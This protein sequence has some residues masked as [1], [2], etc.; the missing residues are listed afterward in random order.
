MKTIKII[1]RGTRLLFVIVVFLFYNINIINAQIGSYCGTC[2]AEGMAWEIACWDLNAAEYDLKK[3]DDALQKAINLQQSAAFNL[4]FAESW[5]ITCKSYW[6]NVIE[7]YEGLDD[8]ATYAKVA[9][10]AARDALAT[11]M[12]TGVGILAAIRAMAAATY[13]VTLAEAAL[14]AAFIAVGIAAG[15]YAIAVAVIPSLENKLRDADAAL[16]VAFNEQMK[17]FQRVLAAKENVKQKEQEYKNCIASIK[18]PGICEK[19]E[20]DKIVADNSQDP[21]ICKKCDNGA[22][23]NDDSENPG[24]CQKCENGA[25]VNECTT[26]QQC[27]NGVCVDIEYEYTVTVTTVTCDGSS[28]YSYTSSTCSAGTTGQFEYSFGVCVGGSI[29]TITCS[30]PYPLPCQ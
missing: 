6:D 25:V 14:P 16:N 22:I 18:T 27:C 8:A 15:T 29:V 5:V 11:A 17:A 7:I 30:E 19:C 4:A 24:P 3:A 21:G 13:A 1:S 9:E 23:V 28:S 10:G 12:R 2:K 20:N 26:G